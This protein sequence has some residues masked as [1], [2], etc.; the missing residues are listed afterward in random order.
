MARIEINPPKQSYGQRHHVN[1]CEESKIGDDRKNNTL[2]YTQ[3]SR[4]LGACI[5]ATSLLNMGNG[6]KSLMHML[7][8]EMKSAIDEQEVSEGKAKPVNGTQYHFICATPECEGKLS[9]AARARQ[10]CDPRFEPR[11]CTECY[12]KDATRGIGGNASV[13]IVMQVSTA[14][15]EKKRKAGWK[16]T[17]TTGTGNAKLARV[18]Q[19]VTFSMTVNGSDDVA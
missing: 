2:S 7:I 1:L 17:E 16:R 3:G 14:A 18:A 5:V 9:E 4:I 6:S 8:G 13:P 11:V 10:R 15:P 19:N 12:F